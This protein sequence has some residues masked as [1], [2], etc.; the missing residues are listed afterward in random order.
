MAL[1][2]THEY[3]TPSAVKM[4]KMLETAGRANSVTDEMESKEENRIFFPLCFDW[5][6]FQLINPLSI[7]HPSYLRA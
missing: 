3:L 7:Y 6:F 4:C 1:N 2:S 5:R